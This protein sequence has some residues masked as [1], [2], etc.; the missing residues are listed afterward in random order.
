[1]SPRVAALEDSMNRAFRQWYQIQQP[2]QVLWDIYINRRKEF[3]REIAK[4]RKEAYEAFLESTSHLPMNEKLKTIKRI[5]LGKRRNNK[6]SEALDSKKINEYAD[7]FR[8]TPNKDMPSNT[9]NYFYYQW[10]KI[11]HVDL[12]LDFTPEMIAL[13]IH[14]MDNGK[15]TGK[16]KIPA[17]AFKIGC[18]EVKIVMSEVF[19]IYARD[20]IIPQ[21]WTR[22]TVIPIYKN[23]DDPREISSYRPISLTE[24]MRKLF[25]RG[26][27]RI[28]RRYLEPLSLYQGGF[29]FRRGTIDQV[30]YLDEYIK[31]LGS[32]TSVVFLDIQKAYDSVDREILW[33]KMDEANVPYN[34]IG[35]CR[36]L[37]NHNTIQVCIDGAYSDPR[38]LDY[39]LLQGSII[40]PILYAFFINDIVKC[41]VGDRVR[42]LLY[43]D[44]IAIVGKN[45]NEIQE[46]LDKVHQHANDNRYMFN[47]RKCEYI[48][49]QV[50]MEPFKMGSGSSCNDGSG[51]RE[52][53]RAN[54][55]TYLGVTF[56]PNGIAWL[57][58]VMGEKA[59]K[60]LNV[61]K[62][63][64]L[65][66]MKI[67]MAMQI[68]RAFIMPIMEYGLCICPERDARM[69]VGTWKNM[70]KAVLGYTRLETEAASIVS[71]MLT[72]LQ[73]RE[74]LQFKYWLRTELKDDSFAIREAVK[75]FKKKRLKRSLFKSIYVE[76]E[77]VNRTRGLYDMKFIMENNKEII[78]NRKDEWLKENLSRSKACK[79]NLGRLDV[80]AYKKL[81]R[82]INRVGASHQ[83][84]LIGWCCEKFCGMWV[85]CHR[86]GLGL[87]RANIGM[88]YRRFPD[89]SIRTS[90]YEIDLINAAESI[91]N[92]WMENH[93]PKSG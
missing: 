75:M 68:L 63:C 34:I 49:K 52:V 41:V 39:G 54:E 53:V 13:D 48:T 17:E 8:D 90:E 73:R 21:S 82:L 80:D 76:N 25:E 60:S 43:A 86:C 42:M 93:Y 47:I 88:C 46:T 28:L 59:S 91:H 31:Q 65:K 50:F 74:T 27:M 69:L 64:G 26:M 58:M 37:F 36:N 32:N 44:D 11:P 9:G 20:R 89:W 72:P 79:E 12:Y 83:K 45:R 4:N 19:R 7:Y 1:M 22:A 51:S 87:T 18:E 55:F 66:S 23:K 6:S 2:N 24:V 81:M 30:A 70:I 14:K 16:S 10:K 3:S 29:R 78:R 40:S 57:S 77:L 92:I 61:L 67:T 85:K 38:K 62:E 35:I 33:K 5:R 15:A 84:M 56:S 71:G